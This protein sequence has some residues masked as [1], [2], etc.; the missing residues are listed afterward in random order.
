MGESP[1]G[2]HSLVSTDG[3]FCDSRA[4]EA[5]RTPGTSSP[6]DSQHLPTL[7]QYFPLLFPSKLWAP[8][9]QEGALFIYNLSNWQGTWPQTDSPSTVRQVHG[10]S[11]GSGIKVRDAEG[12]KGSEDP[13]L[14]NGVFC[15]SSDSD[16]A[17]AAEWGV[18]APLCGPWWE[19]QGS[20]RGVSPRE[21]NGKASGELRAR[22]G[23]KN[24]VNLTI[25]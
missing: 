19:G 21:R 20:N 5:P 18:L 23:S 11:P 16:Q 13:E 17:D 25:S 14:L 8:W 2:A 22:S 10:S 4:R 24:P 3:I 7:H 9:W 6:Y 15:L 1:A 12:A